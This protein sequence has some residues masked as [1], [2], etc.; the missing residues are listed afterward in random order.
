MTRASSSTTHHPSPFWGREERKARTGRKKRKRHNDQWGLSLR[1]KRAVKS[2]E[3]ECGNLQEHFPRAL[4]WLLNWTVFINSAM[5]RPTVMTPSLYK[6]S[7]ENILQVLRVSLSYKLPIGPTFPAQ[8][9]DFRDEKESV[10]Y[11]LNYLLLGL[12]NPHYAFL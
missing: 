12:K 2:E 6:S 1:Y 3:K 9:K 11:Y 10:V 8:T 4:H 7:S 5:I